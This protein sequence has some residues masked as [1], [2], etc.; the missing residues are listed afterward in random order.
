MNNDDFVAISGGAFPVCLILASSLARAFAKGGV[1]HRPYFR[2]L[3]AVHEGKSRATGGT[4]YMLRCRC[5]G[6]EDHEV[7]RA[8]CSA[9]LGGRAAK[10]DRMSVVC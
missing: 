3:A 7:V 6:R 2:A 10:F 1:H 5:G 8:Q 4:D 9:C